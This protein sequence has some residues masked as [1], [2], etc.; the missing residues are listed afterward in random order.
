M[1]TT[2][3]FKLT[4]SAWFTIWHWHCEHD[5]R[6]RKISFIIFLVKCYYWH[7]RIWQPNWLDAGNATLTMVEYRSIPFQHHSDICDTALASCQ[8]HIVNQA[9]LCKI[10]TCHVLRYCLYHR[11]FGC[12]HGLFTLQHLIN[13]TTTMIKIYHIHSPMHL[14]LAGVAK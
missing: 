14:L 13:P 11:W 9:L 10:E 7:P 8:G 12:I 5:E 4:K 3:G 2:F 6:H 1:Y